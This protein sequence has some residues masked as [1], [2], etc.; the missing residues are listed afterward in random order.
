MNRTVYIETVKRIRDNSKRVEVFN[1]SKELVGAL[2]TIAENNCLGGDE[3]YFIKEAATHIEG[4]YNT[5]KWL[6]DDIQE[7][8]KAINLITRGN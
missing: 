1:D 5:F 8:D 6:S 7:V 4:M 3:K 2:L